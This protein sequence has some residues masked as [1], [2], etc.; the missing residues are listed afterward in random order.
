MEDDACKHLIIRAEISNPP[1][2]VSPIRFA[3]VVVRIWL[4]S[5]INNTSIKS[6]PDTVTC[7]SSE[8]NGV[9]CTCVT[10]RGHIGIHVFDNMLQLDVS[11][12]GKLKPI[13]VFNKLY[14]FK[15]I[16]IHWKYLSKT[17]DLRTTDIGI[18]HES[19][20]W[21]N[22]AILNEEVE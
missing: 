18:W 20:P 13:D 14:D 6:R 3:E 11:T 16:V 21:P 12:Y 4:C 17:K 5:L 7:T 8:E 1:A 10:D 22:K 2:P 9:S 15:P 19:S